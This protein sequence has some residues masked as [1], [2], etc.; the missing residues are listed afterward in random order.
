ML[1]PRQLFAAGLYADLSPVGMQPEGLTPLGQQVVFSGGTGATGRELWI[2][3]STSGAKLLKDVNAGEAD[4]VQSILGRAG[5]YVYFIDTADA[6]SL[7]RTDGTAG[8][9]IALRQFDFFENHELAEINGAAVFSTFGTLWR[10][11]GTAAGTT[12][13]KSFDPPISDGPIRLTRAGNRVYF[14]IKTPSVTEIWSTNGTTQ[15]TKLVTSTNNTTH[16]RSTFSSGSGT[17][18]GFDGAGAS[19][20]RRLS[21]WRLNSTNKLARIGE[22]DSIDS[23]TNVQGKTWFVVTPEGSSA[24]SLWRV[25]ETGAA[26]QTG[27]TLSDRAMAFAGGKVLA[28][29]DESLVAIDPET[30]AVTPLKA[31]DGS[32][33][34]M[35]QTE[36]SAIFWVRGTSGAQLLKSNGTVAGTTRIAAN[37]FLPE[38]H[39]DRSLTVVDGRIYFSAAGPMLTQELWTSD[40]TAKGTRMLTDVRGSPED[41]NI[42]NLLSVDEKLYFTTEASVRY[43]TGDGEHDHQ[44]V[45]YVWVTSG[46]KKPSVA[47]AFARPSHDIGL[48]PVGSQVLIRLPAQ[49]VNVEEIWISDGTREG[50]SR[51]ATGFSHTFFAQHSPG[52][53]LFWATKVGSE[54]RQLWASDGTVSGTVKL[55]DL[56]WNSNAQFGEITFLKGKSYFVLTEG[57]SHELWTTD[58]T[59]AGT[60]NLTQW[61][62]QSSTPPQKFKQLTVFKGKLFLTVYDQQSGG[63]VWRSDGTRAGTTLFKNFSPGST[64]DTC[65]AVFDKGLLITSVGSRLS[66]YRSDG[67]V[68]GTRKFYTFPKAWVIHDF[69]TALKLSTGKRLFLQ[70][71][72]NITATSHVYATDGTAA[73]TVRTTLPVEALDGSV[74][75]GRLTFISRGQLMRVS[76]TKAEVLTRLAPDDLFSPQITFAGNRVYY[77]RSTS[78]HGQELWSWPRNT[79]A[80]TIFRDS[81]GDAKRDTNETGL[82]RWHVFFDLDGDGRFDG[83]EPHSRTAADGA[84]ELF[85]L[86]LGTHKLRLTLVS[87]FAPTTPVAYKLTLS[88][89]KRFVRDFGVR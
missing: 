13:I 57:D 15:G 44:R 6:P 67:T 33:R 11:D 29:R 17:Y 30:L 83:N 85:D 16:L 60:K 68:A 80:G 28:K 78:A 40:G 65:I 24:S 58:G 41:S 12:Q 87:G 1:E 50:T 7:W 39:F 86:P 75:N 69:G 63:T 82:A 19:P 9:T 70:V 62:T 42:E 81:D 79:I 20:N 48:A 18:F 38:F 89:G 45:N 88:S 14:A 35:G 31:I 23:M 76:G 53:A 71:Q 52:L 73:G 56:D 47:A 34:L 84:F 21:L 64:Y 25:D 49:T 74:W 54:R 2:G 4:G 5:P 8:G 36:G 22:F 46:K 51:L 61:F 72:Y 32:L 10:S 59:A 43:R 66:L 37:T 55:R 27:L 26:K 3:N 77:L